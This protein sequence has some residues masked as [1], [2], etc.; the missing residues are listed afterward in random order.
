VTL[1]LA[2]AEVWRRYQWSFVR[3]ENELRKVAAHTGS[4]MSLAHM[5]GPPPA[6][7]ACGP[8]TPLQLPP[9]AAM[10]T[11]QPSSVLD[12]GAAVMQRECAVGCNRMT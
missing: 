6:T 3:I 12:G 5:A 2:L 11:S 4:A 1:A 9:Q 7:T 10:L 8:L